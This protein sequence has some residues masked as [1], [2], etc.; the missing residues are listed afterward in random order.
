MDNLDKIKCCQCPN[1]KKYR[2]RVLDKFARGISPDIICKY[3]GKI[4]TIN[5]GV[6]LLAKIMPAVFWGLIA[7]LINTYIFYMPLI[8][9][10]FLAIATLYL[11]MYFVPLEEKK[12][13]NVLEERGK[14]DRAYDIENEEVD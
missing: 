6:S 10:A 7:L 9:W 14:I 3:C 8:V 2:I 1:C 12:K 13:K 5:L 11:I 4:Y